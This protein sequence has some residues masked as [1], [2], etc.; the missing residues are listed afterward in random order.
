MQSKKYV[1]PIIIA[2]SMALSA[3]GTKDEKTKTDDNTQTEETTSQTSIAD[4]AKEMKAEIADLKV[5]LEENDP[6]KAKA[7]GENL[8]EIWE[9]FED[10]VKEKDADLYEQV[11]I[12]LH[13]IEAG[14]E[15]DPLDKDTLNKAAD[16]LDSVLSD[17]EKIK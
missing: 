12:P 4:G 8:E 3:C 1:F 10:E 14:V 15:V 17:V 5:R 9:S 2:A 16:D 11:E 13:L 7:N 6:K